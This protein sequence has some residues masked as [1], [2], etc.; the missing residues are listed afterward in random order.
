[1][2]F[3]DWSRSGRADLRVSNDRHYYTDASGGEEQLWRIEPGEPPRLYTDGGRLADAPDLGHGHRQPGPHRRR[4]PGGLPDQ[5][6]RQQAPDARRR[7]R[8]A[9]VPRHR[10]GARRDRDHAVHGRRSPR[11][12]RLAPPVRGRQQRHATR[13]CS[14]RRATSRPRP[15][16]PRRTRRNLFLGLPD[17]TF[18][19]VADEAGILTFAR[20]R[21]AAI[22]DFNMDGLPD[23]LEVDAAREREALAERRRRHGRGAGA[24][25]QLDRAAADRAG[26]EPRRDRGVGR[27]ED[28]RPDGP[29]TR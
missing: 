1:M 12:D 19:E 9:D 13:T 26:A 28:R 18:R 29:A 16:W 6:G 24:D 4:L 20:G 14:S 17:G 10:P 15:T 5:P 3:S 23:I 7:A 2:L 21:G 27:G 11:L 22:A 25:G 8:P